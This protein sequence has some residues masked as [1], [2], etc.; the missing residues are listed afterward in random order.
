MVPEFVNPKYKDAARNSFKKPT[1]L[2]C[3][4]QDYALMLLK[5]APTASKDGKVGSASVPRMLYSPVKNELSAGMAKQAAGNGSG[6]APSGEADMFG[7][8]CEMMMRAGV[9]MF[10]GRPMQVNRSGI[11][12]DAWPQVTFNA[13]FAHSLQQ[14][15]T[16]LPTPELVKISPRSTLLINLGPGSTLTIKSLNLDGALVIEGTGDFVIDGLTVTNRSW[17]FTPI[18]EGSPEASMDSI[19]IRGYAVEK[20]AT[21]TLSITDGA[22][23]V[24]GA[25]IVDGVV[26]VVV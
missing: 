13:H 26:P 22:S 11:W 15:K 9:K 18:A 20:V 14:L 7:L 16:R 1:R 2:E 3:M 6:T 23:N 10:D 17:R 8:Y 5:M 19:L 24:L 4:M 21:A 12:V 25:T